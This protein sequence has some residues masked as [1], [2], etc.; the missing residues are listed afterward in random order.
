MNGMALRGRKQPVAIAAVL[1]LA[2]LAGVFT[3]GFASPAPADDNLNNL[4]C[5]GSLGKGEP[6]ADDPEATQVKYSF[7]CNGPITG[8][9]IQPQ[10]PVT[11]FETE[12]FGFDTATKSV[13]GPDLFS[14]NGTLPGY[15]VNCVG[16]YGKNNSQ[17]A[18]Y[19]TGQ[20]AIEGDLCDEPRVDALLT[21]VTAGVNGA[22]PTTAIA[23]PFDLGRPH[24]CAG[25][26]FRGKFNSTLRIPKDD[27]GDTPAEIN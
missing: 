20:F 11:G 15:G 10:L 21:V 26:K 19:L 2:A 17:R 22:N 14:C 18:E 9:Q 16:T 5:R 7:S 4:Q 13:V 25:V 12:V 24:G 1:A 3:L 8:F 27:A 23:G 6:S